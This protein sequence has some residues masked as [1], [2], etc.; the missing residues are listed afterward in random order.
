MSSKVTVDISQGIA[1][2]TLNQPKTLNALLPEDYDAL[3]NSLREID[4]NDDVVITVWQA[5]GKWFCAGT[6]VNRSEEKEIEPT[7]RDNFY[8]RVVRANTDCGHALYSHSKILVAALNGPVMAFL[9]NFDF[10]YALP[11]AWLAVPF[12]FLGIIAEGCSSVTFVNRM[13]VAKANEVLIWGKKKTA[14][15]LLEC[16][17]INTIFPDQSTESF[18]TA[19]R[20]HL[21]SELEGLDTAAVLTVKLLI[22]AGLREKN[23]PNSVNL[24]ESYAQAERFS[25]GIPQVRFG[26]IKRKEVRH[27]L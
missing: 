8:A 21:L 14:Q 22:K 7:I 16:G 12:T 23:D 10:I 26:K 3:A 4:K 17:F 6:N 1:T 24:R 25:S 9:G 13:G 15:E 2:I 11:S 19:V 27:K 5:S 18:H 20:A